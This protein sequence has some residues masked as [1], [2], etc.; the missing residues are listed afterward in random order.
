MKKYIFSL[1]VC[2]TSSFCMDLNE[3][4]N[5]NEPQEIELKFKILPGQSATLQ[6]ILEANEPTTVEMSETYFMGPS[7]IPKIELDGYK[8]MSNYLRL[9]KTPKGSFITLKKRSAGAVIEHEV[10]IENTETMDAILQNLG[11]GTTSSEK[12]KLKKRRIKYD[13]LHGGSKIEMVFD[14]FS[15]PEHMKL[16]GT[17]IEVELKS[18]AKSYLDGIRFLKS[19]LVSCG[20]TTIQKYPP[21]IELA[22]NEHNYQDHVEIEAISLNS[23]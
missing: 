15:E 21:Y 13:I 16:M 8:K 1:L 19:F 2:S 10:K 11:Y 18:P 12:I 14:T 23:K 20:V 4:N 22:I 7:C 17:F 6:K 5:S 9:R 3:P